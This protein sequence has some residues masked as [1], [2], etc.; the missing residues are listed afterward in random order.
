MDTAGG[1]GRSGPAGDESY[2]GRPVELAAGLG[3]R[4]RATLMP[5]NDIGNTRIMKAIQY[6]QIAFAWNAKY[7]FYALF[8]QRFDKR[9]PSVFE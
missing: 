4:R 5:G 8:F 3:H 1:I 7:A 6:R 9:L 2:A